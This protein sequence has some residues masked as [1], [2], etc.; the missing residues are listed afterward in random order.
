[1]P[2]IAPIDARQALDDIARRRR[3]VADEIAVPAAYWWAVAAGWIVL[4]LIT[5]TGNA[6][7]GLVATLVFGAV[8]AA[9]APRLLTGRHGSHQLSVSADV[10]GRRL[11]IQLLAGLVAMAAVTVMVALAA[12]AVGAEHPA[13]IASVV[14]AAIILVGGPR[15]VSTA[16]R[17][18][19]RD[20]ERRS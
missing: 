7:A 18:A 9:V 4:G 15:L 11:A 14:V 8:H 6:V 16:R 20:A 13:T 3:Q 19:V 1:M 5:D 17:R 12:D 10:A 2:D